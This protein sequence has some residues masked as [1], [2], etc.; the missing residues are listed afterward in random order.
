MD[1]QTPQ[2]PVQRNQAPNSTDQVDDWSDWFT[3]QDGTIKIDKQCQEQLFKSFDSSLSPADCQKQIIDNQEIAFLFTETFGTNKINVFHHMTITGGSVHE[4]TTQVGFIQGLEK[5]LATF[6]QPDV[7]T[8]LSQPNEA[9]IAIPTITSI[10]A[11]TSATD[12][13]A[14]TD[15]ATTTYKARP[16]IPITPF[17]VPTVKE[18]IVRSNGD[19]SDLLLSTIKDIKSFDTTHSGNKEFKDKAKQKSKDLLFW[20]YLAAKNNACY[21]SSNNDN[22]NSC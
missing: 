20:T 6:Q 19:A 3:K 2:T 9:A 13:Q 11:A 1:Q 16:F 5:D 21:Y 7:D 18:S 15:G 22:I 12:I 8:L 4:P 17:L 14:L 10:L